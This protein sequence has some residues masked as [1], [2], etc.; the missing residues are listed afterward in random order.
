[1]NRSKARV[2]PIDTLEPLVLMSASAAEIDVNEVAS[3]IAID[4]NGDGE[5]GIT[6]QTTTK[7]KSA[8]TAIGETV[9][10]D[11][12]ANG[13]PHDIEWLDG[14]G[15]GILVDIAAIQGNAINGDALFGDSDGAFAS[16][17]EK[18]AAFD[19]DGNRLL[20]NNEISR[21][22]V[23]VDDGNGVLDSNELQ[24]LSDHDIFSLRIE[25]QEDNAGRTRSWAFLLDDSQLITE[26]VWLL[27]TRQDDAPPV[28]VDDVAVTE[29]GQ[30]VT[31]D[32]L[33]NDIAPDQRPLSV[34]G[35]TQAE[36]GEIV[37]NADNTLTYTA[38]DDF[39]GV[40]H[41]QYS[42]S[43]GEDNAIATLRIDVVPPVAVA[44]NIV[45]GDPPDIVTLPVTPGIGGPDP[46]ELIENE[47]TDQEAAASNNTPDDASVPTIVNGTD[48]SEWISGT[49]GD[50]VIRAGAGNDEIHAPIGNNI[51]YGG[52]GVDS[53]IVYEGNIADYTFTIDNDG[54]HVISGPGTNGQPVISV[55][56]NVEKVI[57][58]DGVVDIAVTDTVEP[59]TADDVEAEEPGDT[60]P[61]ESVE[62]ADTEAAATNT[63]PA[64]AS[65]DESEPFA[66][67]TITGTNAGEWIAGSDDDDDIVHAG[68]GDDFIETGEGTNYV[69]GG[70]GLDTF[71]ASDWKAKDVTVYRQ[72]NGSYVVELD[73]SKGNANTTIL[74]NVERILFKDRLVYVHEISTDGIEDPDEDE[75]GSDKSG[76]DSSAQQ[77]ARKAVKQAA[78]KAKKAAE[79]D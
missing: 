79:D 64:Q 65:E 5:I 2:F 29:S 56:I 14:S 30:S 43:N 13:E 22:R 20:E 61:E 12:E 31:V 41:V 3:F 9:E 70:N 37:L 18:L 40:V 74:T 16:G 32:V 11:V 28:A 23:W 73:D 76:S 51:I 57:F 26:D 75:S 60:D 38:P 53:L 45:P 55:L 4:L 48:A 71:M 44:P 39:S 15:D 25:G 7:D 59:E 77:D 49:A 46:A 24:K 58:N 54:N 47:S 50:D 8:V 27:G 66:I 6:G 19:T 33:V 72:S 36:H 78:K 10:F 21:L 52:D 63:E 35:N 17:F 62:P 69:D 1:M 68:G 34:T 67:P 42:I